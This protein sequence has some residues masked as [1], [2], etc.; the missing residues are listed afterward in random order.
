MTKYQIQ[1]QQLTKDTNVKHFNA[2]TALT[3]LKI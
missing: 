1:K 3:N 2:K